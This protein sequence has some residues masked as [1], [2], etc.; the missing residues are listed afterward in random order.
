MKF[1][2]TPELTTLLR[3]IR[4]QNNISA[5]DLAAHISKSPSYISKLESGD[6]KNIRKQDLTNILSFLSGSADFYGEVLPT[7][8]RTLMSYM[9]PERLPEQIWLI[10]YDTADRPILISEEMA[11][12]LNQRLLFLKMS[13][14]ELTEFMN[15]N[16]DS[17]LSSAFPANEIIPLDQK[18][19]TRILVRLD[20]NQKE[21]DNILTGEN[22]HTTY[23]T[24][25][26]ISHAL[27]RLK[28]F[29]NAAYKL[30]PE[31]ATE[32]LRDASAYM[33][34]FQ[35]HSLIGFSHMLSSNDFINRQMNLLNSFDSTSSEL[36]GSLTEFFQEALKHDTLGTVQALDNFSKS[37]N[38]DPAFIL[39]IIQFPFYKMEGL[40]FYQKKNMIQEI[41]ELL[42]KYD[43]LSDFEKKLEIY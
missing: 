28:K 33:Q 30:P 19:S 11:T 8:V 12:D 4:T 26:A 9:S 22:R 17:E 36:I 35:V 39:K 31:S 29:G 42:E 13:T 43:R 37:L 3:T 6:V 25:Y 15:K 27:I 14:G 7:A 38:W 18:G 24:A 40:S 20:V 16:F 10:Q 23:L 5:R 1:T 21:I 41:T 34:H 32:I 2:V